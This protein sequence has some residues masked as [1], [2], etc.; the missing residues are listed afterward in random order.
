[1]KKSLFILTLFILLKPL[2]PFVEYVVNY[3]YISKVLCINRENTVV[4]CDG[5]CYLISQLAKSAEDEKPLSDKKNVVKEIEILFFQEIKYDFFLKTPIEYKS[6]KNFL[7]NN[8]YNYLNSCAT[9][10]PPN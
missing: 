1:M 4:G 2:L 6:I 7:Y 5:K 10:H 3:E 8:L 9:F